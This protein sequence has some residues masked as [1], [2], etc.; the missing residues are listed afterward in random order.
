M[1][2]AFRPVVTPLLLIIVAVGMITL[3]ACNRKEG[4]TDPKAANYDPEANRYLYGSCEYAG[5]GNSLE[6]TY[7]VQGSY[8]SYYCGSSSS[9]Y[10]TSIYT[11]N[12]KTYVSLLARVS[13]VRINLNG[14]S[15]T[16]PTQ[17]N[18]TAT[19][20]TVDVLSGY[21]T[22]YPDYIYI[23]I[24]VSDINYANNCGVVN[25]DLYMYK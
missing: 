21:G 8:D 2:Q 7:S 6:G 17:N 4:C 18:K 5:N 23:Y 13:D 14:T 11:S 3:S 24:R 10:N 15:I 12:N 1:K 16:I 22:N 9:N 20:G 25:W 19:Y